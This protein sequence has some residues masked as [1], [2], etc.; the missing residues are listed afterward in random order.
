[1]T[2]SIFFKH[3]DPDRIRTREEW[4]MRL[5]ALLRP[6]FA[7]IGHP[8][9]DHVRVT[10]GWP[11]SRALSRS[12]RTIGECWPTSASADGSIE[13]FISP[14]LSDPL[15]VAE[16]LVHE[17]VHA[18]GAEGH[19]KDFSRIAKVL[20]LRRPWRATRATP[21]LRRRLNALIS[22]LGPYPHGALDPVLKPQ[23]KDG[24]RML[25]LVCPDDGYTVRTTEKWITTKGRP[26]CPCGTRMERA[27]KIL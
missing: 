17:A 2:R 12:L 6:F 18:T 23:A 7:K 19:L 20:G 24:T 1:V 9:P 14:C 8:I 26:I 15:Q 27:P 22:R 11:S 21:E 3:F 10:C 25:K 13:I 5:L 4:L 16:T